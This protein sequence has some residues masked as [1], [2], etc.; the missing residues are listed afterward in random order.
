MLAYGAWCLKKVWNEHQINNYGIALWCRN[1]FHVNARL[2]RVRVSVVGQ[3]CLLWRPLS[4][5]THIYCTY[6]CRL[7]DR[8]A[9]RRNSFRCSIARTRDSR[10]VTS[11]LTRF[12]FVFHSRKLFVV[13]VGIFQLVEI[14]HSGVLSPAQYFKFLRGPLIS[15]APRRAF[16]H[17]RPC[18]MNLFLRDGSRSYPARHRM[19]VAVR[20]QVEECCWLQGYS[21]V[22]HGCANSNFC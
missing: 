8:S 10:R 1:F 12:R 15:F 3:V 11:T 9:K 7:C 17:W 22:S 6:V 4:S 13:S 14:I 21:N 20:L 18:T 2:S 16:I 5:S 19:C